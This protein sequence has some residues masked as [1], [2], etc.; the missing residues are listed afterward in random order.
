METERIRLVFACFVSNHFMLNLEV[1]KKKTSQY[2]VNLEVQ[3]IL[4]MHQNI[5]HQKLFCQKVIFGLAQKII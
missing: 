1:Q 5:G 4:I 3:T 2:I